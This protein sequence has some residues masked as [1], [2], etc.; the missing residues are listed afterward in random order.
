MEYSKA[1][2]AVKPVHPIPPYPPPPYEQEPPAIPQTVQPQQATTVIHV[3]A[4][5]NYTALS[6]IAC[7]V[8]WPIGIFALLRS[9]KVNKQL[10]VGDIAGAIRSSNSAK[11]LSIIS[12]I[13]G[14]IC[15]ILVI[16]L[17][18]VDLD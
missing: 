4:T 7:L 3:Q 13:V 8:F 14:F 17:I 9:L 12:I 2:E 18:S 6:I 10:C 15:Y 5:P 1:D 11:K 16:V